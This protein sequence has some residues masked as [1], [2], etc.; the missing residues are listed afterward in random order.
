MVEKKQWIVLPAAMIKDMFGLRLS[1]LGLVPQRN[2]RD[3][4]I[5][6]YSYFDVNQETLNVAPTEA[7]QFGRALWC[8]L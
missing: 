5:S 3:R 7:M 4:M 1:L 8:L 2:R 6:D